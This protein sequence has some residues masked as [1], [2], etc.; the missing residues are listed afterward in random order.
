[1]STDVDTAS[2]FTFS[3]ENDP[4]VTTNE[5]KSYTPDSLVDS[6]NVGSNQL[7]SYEDL[8]RKLAE[9]EKLLEETLEIKLKLEAEVEKLTKH[10]FKLSE[11]YENLGNSLH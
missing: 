4:V 10:A 1:M 3:L 8:Q 2:D 7:L 5:Q 9:T 11:K 6:S